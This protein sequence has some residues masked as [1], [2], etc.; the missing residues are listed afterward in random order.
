MKS[1]FLI[2]VFL[3]LLSPFAQS[4]ITHQIGLDIGIGGTKLLVPEDDLVYAQGLQS[5]KFLTFGM[6]AALQYDLLLKKHLHLGAGVAAER[7]LYPYSSIEVYTVSVPLEVGYRSNPWGKVYF[8]ADALVMP[9]YVVRNG[10]QV[11]YTD[12][13]GN[14]IDKGYFEFEH[15]PFNLQV[16]LQAGLGF[17]LSEKLELQISLLSKVDVLEHGPDE[18]RLSGMLL[19][20]GLRYNL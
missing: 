16:G 5:V 13:Q 2:V 11:T 14:A 4:Q 9:H 10:F 6:M 17:I 15:R 20:V 3:L 8:M 1:S 19:T 12:D 18:E 7:R